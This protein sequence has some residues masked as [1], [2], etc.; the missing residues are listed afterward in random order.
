MRLD[1]NPTTV[2]SNPDGEKIT[3]THIHIYTEEHD[4]GF[5]MPFDVENRDLYQLCYSF[6]EQFNIVEPPRVI[7]QLGVTEESS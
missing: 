7:Q 5:A 6:F 2:H 3:G 4:M 1:V